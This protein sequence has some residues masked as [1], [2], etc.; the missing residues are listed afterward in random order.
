MAF[1][2]NSELNFQDEYFFWEEEC[3]PQDIALVTEHAYLR[4]WKEAK[5]RGLK[6]PV[7]IWNKIPS[8]NAYENGL[9]NYQAFCAGRK[10]AFEA[11]EIIDS[12]YPAASAVGSHNGKISFTFLFSNTKPKI[13]TNP[14]QVEAYKYP[15]T[16]GPTPP[17]FA[18][19]CIHKENFHLSGTA[20]IRGHKTLYIGDL[21]GQLALTLENI[22]VVLHEAH[23]NEKAH[24]MKWTVFIK[25]PDFEKE[26]IQE[27]QI[28][29]G[30]HLTFVHADICR[31]D[32]LIEIEGAFYGL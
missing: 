5:E 19:G 11:L 23:L 29:L 18:R 20:S 26:V 24:E 3:L 8:I 30:N 9:E 25:D 1:D 16:Y 2:L 7:R 22:F 13:V 27:I 32:L 6:F 17:S 31:S 21:K 15:N 10:N 14:Y 28:A 12:T 4:A